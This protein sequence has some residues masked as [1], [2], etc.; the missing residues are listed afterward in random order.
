[1]ELVASSRARAI[2]DIALMVL[3][4]G[5]IV[6]ILGIGGVANI[7]VIAALLAYIL[8]PLATSLEVRGLSR[9]AATIVLF[10]SMGAVIATLAFLLTPVVIDQVQSLQSGSSSEQASV[11]VARMQS[12]IRSKIGFLGLQDFNL[13]DAI[14][15]VKGYINERVVDFVL[16]DSLALLIELVTIPFI[17]FFLIKDGREIKKRAVSLVPNRYF[18]FALDLIYKMDRQLGNYMRGQFMDAMIFGMLATL[19]MWLL[20]VKYFLFIGVFAGLA[21]LIPFVGPIAGLL[22]AVI[23]TVLDTGDA[24]RAVFVILTFA[25]LKI[26]DDVIVQPLAVGKTVNLHPMV[27]A[28]AILV[29]GHLFGIL[30]MLLAVP[31]TGFLKVVFMESIVT[32]RKYRFS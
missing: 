10:L 9:T 27:V 13:A 28:I 26:I 16:N 7:L 3:F 32:F 2:R 21:N 5:V 4:L 25:C 24:K 6:V 29:G 17:M 18:E 20:N 14:Q 30:G 31:C 12:L 1:M 8:D 11:A 23:V 22:P 15:R 19:A